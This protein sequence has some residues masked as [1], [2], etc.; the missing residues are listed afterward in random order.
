MGVARGVLISTLGNIAPVVAGLVTA[1]L[2]AQSLGVSGRGEL[3]AATAPL[4]LAIGAITFGVPEAV[5]YHVARGIGRTRTIAVRAGL[6]LLIAGLLATAVVYATADQLSG[7]QPELAHLI[8]LAAF[9][10]T[11]G[12]LVGGVRGYAAGRSLWGLIAAER[13]VSALL[14]LLTVVVLSVLGTL[15]PL[16]ATIAI[17]A[18]TIGGGCV[19]LGL[20]RSKYERSAPLTDQPPQILRFGMGLWMGTLAGILLSRM[21]QLVMVPL[22]GTYMLGIYAVAVTISEIVLV[23]NKSVRDVV[24]SAESVENQADRLS[25]ASRISTLVTAVGAVGIGI[26]SIPVIPW[27]F[28]SDFAPAIPVTL[29]LLLAVVLGNPGSVAGAGLSARGRP[30]LRSVSLAIAATINIGLLFILVPLWGATG[31]ALATL[32]GNVIAGYS[33]IFWM[34]FF[35]GATISSYL[36]F[37][38][39]DLTDAMAVLRG[40]LRRRAR[41]TE[42]EAGG[43]D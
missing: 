29:L 27:L 19:Y 9:A 17:A 15:T 11:P 1:P 14:R 25:Q 31:A 35:F 13:A 2:L 30:V 39:H 21:D 32:A 37:R 23:F 3:A 34:K 42:A 16:S 38:R 28:G 43:T 10:I 7:D 24:F 26:L 8:R 33:N 40:L 4:L 36:G 41:K 22:S 20:F 18:T 12:L 5:T 6:S